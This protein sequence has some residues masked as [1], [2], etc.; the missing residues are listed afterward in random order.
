M[1][2]S[3]EV[4]RLKFCVHFS[5]LSCVIHPPSN[6]VLY[7]LSFRTIECIRGYIQ[8]FP[9]WVIK[10][11]TLTTI[12]TSWETIQR[13]MAAKLTRLTHKI[14]TQPHLVAES[15]TICSSRSRRS[16]RKLLDTPA[17]AFVCVCVCVCVRACVCVCVCVWE[18][19]KVWISF[20]L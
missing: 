5:S 20:Q 18:R 19:E 6:Y 8:T 2:S 13:V 4:S 10:K 7:C 15:C 9:D 1:V 3:F 11:C 17:R 16:V 12:N 14:A